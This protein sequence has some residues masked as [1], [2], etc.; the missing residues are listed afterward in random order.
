MLELVVERRRLGLVDEVA[1]L[2]PPPGDG[3]GH[4]VDHLAQRP[5]ALGGAEPRKYFWATMLVALTDHVTGE[6]DPELLE[7]HRAVA[8]VG[9][10]CVAALPLDLVVGVDRRS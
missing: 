5:L 9:D 4:P 1:A 10:A 6:L 3:V 7:G 8:V 2:D